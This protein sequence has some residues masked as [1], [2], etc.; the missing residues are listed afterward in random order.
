VADG[1]HVVWTGLFEESLEVVSRPPR[2]MLVVVCNNRDA[3]HVRAVC[4]PVVAVVIVDRG[5]CPLR[6]L[7]APL[8][9]ILSALLGALDGDV[10][11]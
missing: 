2:L 4:L 11:R 10:G 3:P 9:A 6:T 8:F 5:R 7:L 1:A